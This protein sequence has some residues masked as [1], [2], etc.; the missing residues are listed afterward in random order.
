[1]K[2]VAEQ[3][4]QTNGFAV[5][6]RRLTKS[7]S[8]VTGDRLAGRDSPNDIPCVER[9]KNPIFVVAFTR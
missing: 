1:M 7:F 4:V 9:Y 2:A 8:E 5:G 6:P 3:G